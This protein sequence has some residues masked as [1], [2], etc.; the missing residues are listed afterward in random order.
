MCVEVSHGSDRAKLASP[1]RAK[2]RNCNRAETVDRYNSRPDG[3][4]A[5]RTFM[6]VAEMV[7]VESPR[8]FEQ[9]AERI[10]CKAISES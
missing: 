3:D 2:M 9:N 4:D 7:G 6:R 8:A 1:D 5:V 10:A